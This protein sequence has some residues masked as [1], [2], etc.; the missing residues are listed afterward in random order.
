ML[1]ELIENISFQCRE[2][3]LVQAS[4]ILI[5]DKVPFVAEKENRPIAKRKYRHHM[6]DVDV[7]LP[8]NR[9]PE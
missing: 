7:F 2:N 4:I 9:Q 1:Q 6:C 8:T 3:R 5:G